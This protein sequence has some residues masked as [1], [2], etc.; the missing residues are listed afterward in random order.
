MSFLSLN[1]G[2][3]FSFEGQDG[4]YKKLIG[5]TYVCLGTARSF[6]LNRGEN[7]RVTRISAV[8]IGAIPEDAPLMI[9]ER[10]KTVRGRSID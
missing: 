9:P 8:V 6:K 3:V 4:Q 2:D 7:P 10:S 1:C 5:Y